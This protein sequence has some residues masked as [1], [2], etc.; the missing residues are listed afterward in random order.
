M[1]RLVAVF[2]KETE[3]QSVLN[4]LEMNGFDTEKISLVMKDK[5]EVVDSDNLLDEED[6]MKKAEY[7]G[8]IHPLEAV[9]LD[10]SHVDIPNFGQIIVAGPLA[11]SVEN[12]SIGGEEETEFALDQLI[13]DLLPDSADLEAFE[14]RIQ[15][16]QIFLS[17]EADENWEEE[18]RTMITDNNPVWFEEVEIEE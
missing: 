3:V 16:N 1:K 12:A 10:G 5:K 14:N 17:V 8:T 6:E 7:Y 13:Y 9:N 18:V 15:A 4:Q 11:N 2:A